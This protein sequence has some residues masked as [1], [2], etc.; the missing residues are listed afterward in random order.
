MRR[1]L[2]TAVDEQKK[3]IIELEDELQL[4]NDARMRSEVGRTAT[5]FVHT[6]GQHQRSA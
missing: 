3:Q 2:Q 6:I 1:E 4:A 5:A